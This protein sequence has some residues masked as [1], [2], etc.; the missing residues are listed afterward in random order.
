M[1]LT[2]KEKLKIARK[3]SHNVLKEIKNA[4]GNECR[5]SFRSSLE[6]IDENGRCHLLTKESFLGFKKAGMSYGIRWR[7]IPLPLTIDLFMNFAKASQPI[8]CEDDGDEVMNELS[9]TLSAYFLAN[10]L[11]EELK[12][13]QDHVDGII[14]V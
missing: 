2:N 8:E 12:P 10:Q 4:L 13:N 3:Q 1:D 11:D 5:I 6:V 7:N 9:K 14:K